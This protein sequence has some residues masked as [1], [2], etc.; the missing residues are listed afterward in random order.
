MRRKR[1]PSGRTIAALVVTGVTPLAAQAA[2]STGTLYFSTF[3]VANPLTNQV[4]HDATINS[5]NFITSPR[6]LCG[7]Q[8]PEISR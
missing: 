6:N 8:R 1:N 3:R 4:F 5:V 7:E 2:T